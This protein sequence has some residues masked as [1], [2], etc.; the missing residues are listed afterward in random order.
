VTLSD[1]EKGNLE[2][3]KWRFETRNLSYNEIPINITNLYPTFDEQDLIIAGEVLEHVRDPLRTVRN[4][5]NCLPE[6]GHLWTSSYPY[7]EKT[8]GGTHLREAFDARHEVLSFLNE[9]FNK[10][11]IDKGYLLQKK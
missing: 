7:K 5:Y 11:D 6:G 1:I 2:F 4:F 9:N 3:A 8:V 10:I